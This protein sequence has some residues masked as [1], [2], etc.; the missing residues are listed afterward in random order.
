MLNLPNKAA[1][2]RLLA[3]SCLLFVLFRS[4]SS[5]EPLKEED[6]PHDCIIDTHEHI[7]SRQEAQK[8]L[9][10]MDREGIERVVLVGSPSELLFGGNS[11]GLCF[12]NPEQNNEELLAIISIYPQR[13][14]AFATYSPKDVHAVGKL[15]DF[16]QR[17]GTG[18]KLY[19][20]HYL[21]HDRLGVPLDAPHLMDLYAFCERQRV[22][23]V[24]HANARFYWKELEHVLD[25]YPNLVVNLAH[26]CMSLI[27]LERIQKIFD[28][29]PNVYADVSF[30]AA[31]HAYPAFRWVAE[32][33]DR[34]RA[35][36]QRYK[37][38][39]L[40]AT[41]MVLTDH[42]AM[43]EIYVEKMF[44]G[45]RAF[46]E[47]DR[48]TN[49]LIEEYLEAFGTEEKGLESVLRGLELDADTL[50]HIYVRNPKRFL[51]IEHARRRNSLKS[52]GQGKAVKVGS[53]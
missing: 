5:G 35:F 41:D 3:L 39:F 27:D 23:I 1:H 36:V 25:A 24:F 38:R 40:F 22:P 42:P 33:R 30:G 37:D 16:L 45:Y 50:R 8:L 28:R 52:R 13:F 11:K 43:D 51:G 34:Y 32:R 20:G 17:G 53:R 12:G 6:R 21:Y 18:L 29:Y 10:A 49:S 44:R 19:T 46:L 2:R 31:E 47:K 4:P 7:Q 26:F 15:R 48:Y 9:T 14:F